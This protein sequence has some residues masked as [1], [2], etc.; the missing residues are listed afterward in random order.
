MS[1]HGDISRAVAYGHGYVQAEL[2]VTVMELS[3]VLIL[4]GTYFREAGHDVSVASSFA[5][6]VS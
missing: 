1:E 6:F 5:P 3:Q 4:M 2:L